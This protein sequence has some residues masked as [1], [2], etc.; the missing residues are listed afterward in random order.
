[1]QTSQ[2]F[3][4]KKL[5]QFVRLSIF[6]CCLSSF[7]SAHNGPPFPIVE[8]KQIGSV[9]IAVWTHPDIGIGTFFV[10]VDPLPGSPIPNDLKI[11]LGIQPVSNRVSEVVYPMQRENGRANCNTTL[12]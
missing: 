7:A 10:L 4:Q 9:K 8:D 5:T 6:L 12:K 3:M 1:M 2:E 11:D